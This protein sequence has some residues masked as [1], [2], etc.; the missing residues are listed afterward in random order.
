MSEEGPKTAPPG[1][2]ATVSVF[3][4]VAPQAA[5]EA[6][7]REID[8][9]WRRG[10]RYRIAGRRA[11]LLTFEP[12]VGGRLLETVETG[13]GPRAFE[14]GLITGWEPAARLEFEWRG[15]NFE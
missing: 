1:D 6:F 7:T 4:A 8:L 10:P 9:W 11:G 3:V 2:R 13:A 15:V 12:R 14:V 5:F